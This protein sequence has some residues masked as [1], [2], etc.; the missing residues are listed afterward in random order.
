M[1]LSK[2]EVEELLP[3]LFSGDL[4]E[5]EKKLI[6]E[7]RKESPD[8]ESVYI[9]S[10]KA[11]EAIPLLDVMEK[12]NSFEAL[13]KI[14]KKL[15][16]AEH[17]GLLTLIQRIAAVLLL[18]VMV[19][20]VYQTI[21]NLSLK[22]HQEE[23]VV[24]Q[25]VSSRQ[26]MI[27][28][29]DLPDGTKVWLNSG[30]QLQFPLTFPSDIREVNLK[31]EAFFE[32]AKNENHPFIVN[33]KELNVEVI[34]TSFNF[35]SY[36]N[37]KQSEVILFEGEVMLTVDSKNTTTKLGTIKP[38]QRAV[39]MKESK[40]MSTE[41]VALEKY[42]AWRDGNLIFQDDSMDDVVKRLSRWFNVEFIIDDPEINEYIYKA[43]FRNENLKQ[44]LNLLKI[45]APIDYHI[46]ERRVLP[47]GEFTKQKIYI[48]KKK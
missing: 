9:E 26:G 21:Q 36:D 34:G 19:Y 43:T 31:G 11:W 10:C 48:T 1:K 23:N 45:S 47:D 38:G 33:S 30:S 28:E 32:V 44:V 27:A 17:S 7:W 16:K 35:I 3:A 12:F 13:K 40:T 29:F 2:N 14:D 22:K 8:N 24:M 5:N 25:T 15:V 4:S 42:I 6:D 39:F 18:P 37:E 46:L 20:S 41:E